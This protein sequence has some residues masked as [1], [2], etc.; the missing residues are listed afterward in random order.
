M[1]SITEIVFENSII[2]IGDRSFLGS[3]GSE[4]NENLVTVTCINPLAKE[5]YD[6]GITGLKM[7]GN[8]VGY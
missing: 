6:S 5:K 7:T 1:S 2:Y 4:S 3:Y 8:D